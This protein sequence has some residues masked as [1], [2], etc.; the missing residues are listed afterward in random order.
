MLKGWIPPLCVTLSFWLISRHRNSGLRRE[1]SSWLGHLDSL[2]QTLIFVWGLTIISD[3]VLPSHAGRHGRRVL[4]SRLLLLRHRLVFPEPLS[5][6]VIYIVH[7]QHLSQSS[8]PESQ[9]RRKYGSRRTCRLYITFYTEKHTMHLLNQWCWDL[10]IYRVIQK[11]CPQLG[12]CK[13]GIFRSFWLV[14]GLFLFLKKTNQEDLK[15]PNLQPPDWGQPFWMT[16]YI[17][18]SKHL[19][20]NKCIVCF[21]V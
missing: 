6:I 9:L 7:W 10:E 8:R 14:L 17:P 2:V 19:W 18:K 13:I 5:E 11:G 12:G 3:K 21:S 15:I 4:L 16:Q 1:G 20:F